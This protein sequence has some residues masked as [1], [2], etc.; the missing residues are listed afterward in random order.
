VGNP[1]GSWW[2]DAKQAV[3]A[4]IS[5]GSHA[6]G[7][8]LNAVGLHGAA[9]AVDTLGDKAGY[10]LGADVPELQLGQTADPAELVHGDP[11]AIR[12]S[13]S[14]LR[15]FSSA[16]GETASGLR[17]LDTA[18]WTGSAADAFR[19]KFAPQPAR[20]Q[21][22]S[23]ANGTASGALESYAGAVET[24]QR[25][26]RQAIDLYA[27]GEQAT[28]A[29]QATYHQQ[30][31]AY[32]SAAQAYNAR[33]AS[34]Q[35]PGTPPAEPAPFTDPGA[36]LRQQAQQTLGEARSSRDAAAASAA[37]AI[38]PATDLAPAEPSFLSQ[39]GDDLS[40]ALQVS[41]LASVSFTGGVVDG[42]AD[43]VKFAQSINPEN[44]WNI[45]HPAEYA[46]GLSGT[47]AG[48]TSDA[49]NPE[50]LVKGLVG[51][52]W[53]SD[54]FQAA[55]RLAPS[56]ALAAGTD[57][58]GAAADAGSV[59]ESAALA[60][61]ESAAADA[62]SA[63]GRAAMGSGEDAATRALA[64]ATG[65][66][67][68]AAVPKDDVP[69]VNDPIDVVTGDV[70]L[71]QTDVVL[72]G[73]LPLVVER[74]H[75]SSW[76]AGRWFGRS[77]VST[78]D[79]R[80]QVDGRRVI[81]AFADGRV[82]VW[83]RPE[84]SGQAGDEAGGPSGGPVLPVAGA[85]WPLRRQ[86]DGGWTV[87]DPQRG[88]TWRFG[89]HSG[90]FC[91]S[92]GHGELPLV[93]VH[94]RAGHEIRFGYDETG[95]PAWIRHS[96]GYHV[97]VTVAAG[98]VTSLATGPADGAKLLWY[99]YDGD[100]N[101]AGV[102]NSSRRP[103]VF[104]YDEAGRLTQ[105]RDR[106]GHGYGYGYDDQGRCVRGDG[107]G[108]VLSGTVRY[109]PQAQVTTSTDAAGAVTTYRLRGAYV[110]A[111]TDPLGHE[112]RWKHD[113]RGQLT[114]RTDP[115]GR[116]TRYTFDA[117][118]NLAMITR[119][120]GSQAQAEYDEQDL[121][122][123]L[124]EPGG[125]VWRQEYDARGNRTQ[126]T[127]PDGSVTRFCHDEHGHLASI[128]DPAGA[129]TLVACNA[130]G[131]PMRVT[132]ANGAVTSLERDPLGRVTRIAGPGGGITE[133]TWTPEGRPASR[134]LPDGTAEFW[135]YD[136]EGNLTRHLSAAGALTRCE[137]GPFHQLA[138]TIAPDGS[139]TQL[140]YDHALR[141]TS[142]RHGGLTWSYD[143]DL[144]GRLVAETDFN[145][146][147][148][149]YEHDAGGQLIAQVNACGQRIAYCHDQLGNVAERA[150]GRATTTFGYDLAGRLVYARN[151]EA[152]IWLDRDALGR[153]T[154][155]TCNGRT[156][157]SEYDAAGRRRRRVTPFGAVTDW[158]HDQAGQ[159][160]SVTAGGHQIQFDY[161]EAGQEIRR[162]LPGGLVLAQDWDQRGRLTVQSLTAWGQEQAARPD[163]PMAAGPT[164]AGRPLVT[165][166]RSLQ[167]RA[168]A[169]NGD[170]LVTG[171]DDV[172]AGTRRIGLDRSGRV[173]AVTG[174]DW[175]ENYAYDPAGNV[176]AASWP[177]P[178]GTGLAQT[179]LWGAFSAACAPPSAAGLGSWAQGTRQITGT[180]ISRAGNVRYR[181]D[182]QGRVIQR[183]VLRISRKPD[184][185][186]YRWDAGSR[187]AGVTTPDGTTWRY[188]YDPFG[189]R[190]AKQRLTPNGDVAEQ[191]D[192]IWDGPVLAEQ[193][194]PT[195]RP[196][197]YE[198]VTWDYR[199]GS[200]TALTQAEHTS[201]GEPGDL[202]DLGD[203]GEASQEQIDQRFYAIIA[204]LVGT[205]AELVA[206]DG[207]LAGRQQHTLW[208]TTIWRPDG[209]Q[210]PL[211]FPGQYADPETG[212]HYN[213]HRY[214][215]P[216]AGS[217]LT[218]DPLGL[219]AAPN[220][221]A[222]VPNPQVLADP[223]GL[224]PYEP[225]EQGGSNVLL[226]TGSVIKY[227][228]ARRLLN[229][230]DAPVAN[231]TTV[232]ELAEVGA[233]K[234]FVGTLPDGVSV[235]PDDTG[236]VLRGQVM[237][238]LR[239]FNAATLGIENDAAVGATALGMGIPLI[240]T[241]YALA[242][243]VTKL[244][245]MLRYLE[246]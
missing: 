200:F 221:H 155:E 15:T 175:D 242:N 5:D 37:A 94:D 240:T 21:D 182:R 203:L 168:Y 10:D 136:A 46:A 127:A 246:P 243:A 30:V 70:I 16:F 202:G 60:S 194:T 122:V 173:T 72:P 131:L 89:R 145:G 113:E 152:E 146:A 77:W 142:V 54:P 220:P 4:G 151:P 130:A 3:G 211:R 231:E 139:R 117:R 191:T 212:L 133:L 154:A 164:V 45:E 237:Q 27:Q 2:N 165:G 213:Q 189:R 209:A 140:G 80:L 20:W 206:P 144:A 229:P 57:G 185:W 115:L 23:S 9:Q 149:S 132:G 208:G 18:H 75:R 6:L 160:V 48:L 47:A 97:R 124:T 69:T 92:A 44:P 201:A 39:L 35:D 59:T 138:A 187:L 51:T 58:A 135:D 128:T 137:Y 73:V 102:I 116:V 25:G 244:G 222:Y 8:G 43:I 88:L 111:M 236:M 98:R 224:T 95:A 232:R 171:I 188:R 129:V 167:R 107:P 147:R 64:Q 86:P 163:G 84:D 225:T 82:L 215:D 34:G 238:Q 235:I 41:S 7:D 13:A 11:A 210:T 79:Q 114:E 99:S 28:A 87:S 101:L 134:S 241:D 104:R 83:P 14:R 109:D 183:Q 50:G 195:A 184:T 204:D 93:A 123:G 192:F 126:V 110:V 96:G 169:Y 65:D 162:E 32:N 49:I 56:I 161:D 233:R 217:Y 78:F 153:I 31:A 24:A 197:Q 71:A 205:P 12:S 156:V 228:S 214:Y 230:G 108:G 33:L 218:P 105:W 66:P 245:G 81:G 186:H 103:L 125:R 36:T 100:G 17:G 91:S 223:L 38:R 159:L 112:S 193:A 190:I 143:Y 40:D 216:M 158:D 166:G 179:G 172:L 118:G 67:G 63:A 119:P 90:Y 74:M 52:G 181:H 55:G 239:M 177:A 207:T 61:G 226:D 53:G 141:M 157:T 174:P 234:G 227:N 76:R 22:A 150:S 176:S 219:A 1:F 148:T 178:P 29:A 199:P 180:L 121:P 198:V 42:A 62:G 19:A 196:G 26:A 85:P 106:N 68:L 170:G 120:D